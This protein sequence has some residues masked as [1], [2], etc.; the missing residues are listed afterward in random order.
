MEKEDVR[1]L[2]LPFLY[3]LA[4]YN[5]FAGRDATRAFIDLCFTDSCLE[6]ASDL[7][8]LTPE[9]EKMIDEWEDFYEAEGKYPFIGYLVDK[10]R[11]Y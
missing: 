11:R 3:K 2:L 9:Q 5:G 6:K 8:D 7:S 4:E 1:D 10:K